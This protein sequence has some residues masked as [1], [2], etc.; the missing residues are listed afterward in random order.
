MLPA[1]QYPT[2]AALFTNPCHFIYTIL[3]TDEY[4]LYILYKYLSIR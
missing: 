1:S 4:Y 3:I 2:W